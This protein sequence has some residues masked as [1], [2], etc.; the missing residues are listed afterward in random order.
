CSR[1]GLVYTDTYQLAALQSQPD[2]RGLGWQQLTAGCGGGLHCR[3]ACHKGYLNLIN[4]AS[5]LVKLCDVPPGGGADGPPAGCGP[6]DTQARTSRGRR[7]QRS[8][9][10]GA[11]QQSWALGGVVAT[12]RP[13]SAGGAILSST[14][15]S[16]RQVR[17]I[18]GRRRQTGESNAGPALPRLPARKS[19]AKLVF[20]ACSGAEWR[21]SPATLLPGYKSTAPRRT[22]PA[23]DSTGP[24][25]VRA[26]RAL[27]RP[28]LSSTAA[29]MPTAQLDGAA[30]FATAWGDLS[31]SERRPTR[32]DS[33][34][35]ACCRS[36]RIGFGS[37]QLHHGDVV[38]DASICAGWGQAGSPRCSGKTAAQPLVAGGPALRLWQLLG[39]NSWTDLCTQSQAGCSQGVRQLDWRWRL[40]KFLLFCFAAAATVGL[41]LQLLGRQTAVMIDEGKVMPESDSAA[42]KADVAVADST[43]ALPKRSREAAPHSWPW[44]ASLRDSSDRHHC[45][46]SVITERWVLTAA[47]CFNESEDPTMWSV[48]AGRHCHNCSEPAVQR[49]AL[50]EVVI[51][52]AYNASTLEADLA[53]LL[54]ES[55]LDFSGSAPRPLRGDSVCTVTGWGLPRMDAS[56]AEQPISLQEVAVPIVP[57]SVCSD[58]DHYGDAV[59]SG[60]V[61][62]AG[63]ELGGGDACKGYSGGPLVCRDAAPPGCCT[64]S[65]A[66]ATAAPCRASRR[67]ARGSSWRRR[68]SRNRI[69]TVMKTQ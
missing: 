4:R 39:V 48:D 32:H 29:P 63:Y 47:H 50:A 35:V 41:L 7:S 67:P 17:P 65:P 58:E 69:D 61:L 8:S 33:Q 24:L 53:L 37:N 19:G 21:G 42:A 55:P 16:P 62:C 12:A 14:G 38:T 57:A 52:P 22:R 5:V 18:S 30:C 60:S 3:Q 2:V 40:N 31:S 9:P 36:C 56:E 59:D 54:L 27:A 45:G 68:S 20:A 25:E 26:A 34:Q 46:G 44:M 11:E 51:H 6:P 49:R 10:S 23:G 43:P 15:L 66:G 28:A 64:A 13:S 1:T